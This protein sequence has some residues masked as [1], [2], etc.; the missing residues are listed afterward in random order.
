M[1]AICIL[2]DNNLNVRGDVMNKAALFAGAA[3]LYLFY[4]N[5]GFSR[6][7]DWA[8]SWIGE[9]AK[10]S[11]KPRNGNLLQVPEPRKSAVLDLNAASHDELTHLD[12][13]DENLAERVIEN[14]PYHSK[15]DLLDRMVLPMNAYKEVKDSVTVSKAG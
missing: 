9:G 3:I 6:L 1:A 10:P 15:L 8:F 12:G 7:E 5:D 4:A 14:R 11:L 2:T 13:L